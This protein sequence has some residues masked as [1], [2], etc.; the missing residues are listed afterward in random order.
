MAV[1]A[2][3]TRTAGVSPGTDEGSTMITTPNATIASASGTCITALAR[4][5]FSLSTTTAMTAIQV[6]LITPNA[7]IIAIDA[8]HRCASVGYAVTVCA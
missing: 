6:T 5:S 2:D 1:A 8:G 4:T 3:V 7:G